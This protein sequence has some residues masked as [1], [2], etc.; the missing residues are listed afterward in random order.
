MREL[1]L[2]TIELEKG[3]HQPDHTFCVMEAV[4]F[5][6]GEKW[7]DHPQCA[8][9]VI[10]TFLRRINDRFPNKQRQDLK[11]FIIPLINSKKNLQIEI[12]R[13]KHLS[14]WCQQFKTAAYAAA[15]AAADAAA[16]AAAYAAADSVSAAAADAVSAAAVSAVSAAAYAAYDIIWNKVLTVIKEVLAINE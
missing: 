2:A 13:A 10:S 6:A 4:A 16:Y 9:P 11:Q 15:Y 3:S 14:D 5:I 1:D 12:K 8:C 7:T